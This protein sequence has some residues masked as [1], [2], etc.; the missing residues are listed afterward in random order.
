MGLLLRVSGLSAF[1][2]SPVTRDST[3]RTRWR[4]CPGLRRTVASSR[5]R[6]ASA[7]PLQSL[8]RSVGYLCHVVLTDGGHRMRRGNGV[9]EVCIAT[10]RRQKIAAPLTR[11]SETEIPILANFDDGR[12]FP[13]LVVCRLE[14]E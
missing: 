6:G 10:L 2:L 4:G 14:T 11:L 9:A 1:P 8:H 5:R 7:R 3:P 12:T 13:K